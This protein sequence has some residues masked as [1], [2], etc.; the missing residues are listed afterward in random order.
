MPESGRLFVISGPSGVGKSTVIAGVMAEYPNLHFSVSAT[1]RPIRPGEV[2]GKNYF[3]VS[4]ER[5]AEMLKNGELL[6]HV[7]YVS[8]SYGTPE[9]PLQASLDAGRDILLDIEPVGALHVRKK[10]PDA[11][12]IFLA[13][14]SLQTLRERLNGRCDTAPELIESRLERARWELLQAE[15]YDYIVV[16]DEVPHA[17]G[18][19]L[20]ILRGEPA[21]K[22]CRAALRSHILKEEL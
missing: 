10:R 6:E 20:A 17:V 8:N 14:P 22:N 13:P 19:I 11:T 9:A 3:F 21:A 18:E 7:E 16:N 12:L 15:K 5:F 1:T 4:H 2:D